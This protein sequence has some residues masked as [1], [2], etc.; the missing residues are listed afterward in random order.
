LIGRITASFNASLAWAK[1]ATSSHATFGDSDKIAP[2]RPD[3]NF[4]IS[5]SSSSP[6]PLPL[7]SGP[8]ADDAPPV[9]APTF[10][11][12]RFS[13]DLA[14]CSFSFSARSR[15]SVNFFRMSSLSLSFFSSGH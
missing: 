7:T 12:V 5:G 13:S 3:L 4:L 11:L 9:V 6:F 1:P 2:C 10:D 14:M 15:Y 8:P